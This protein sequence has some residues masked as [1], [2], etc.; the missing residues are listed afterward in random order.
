MSSITL[1]EGRRNKHLSAGRKQSEQH[2]S[3]TQMAM[4]LYQLLYLVHRE[5]TSADLIANM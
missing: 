3:C 5:I 2:L 4:R 1:G